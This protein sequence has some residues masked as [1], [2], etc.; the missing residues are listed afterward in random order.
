MPL[1]SFEEL[2]NQLNEMS[3]DERREKIEE[4]QLDCV[5]PICP[6]YN[7]CAKDT[8]EN[9]FCLKGKSNC[10]KKEK[11]C[12]CPTCPFAAEFKIGVIYNF[13]C[14]RGLETDQR[15]L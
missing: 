12:M 2:T 1:D 7:N 13:Y 3:D 8:G 15:K 4:L 6:T 9:I 11:G 14:M 10:V 5:C